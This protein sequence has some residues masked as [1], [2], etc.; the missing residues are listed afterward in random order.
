M[1]HGPMDI[2]KKISAYLKTDLPD[3][4]LRYRNHWQLDDKMLPLPED[5]AYQTYHPAT[6]L[7]RTQDY[8][9]IFTV[10]LNTPR[11]S[12]YGYDRST[13]DPL[14]QCEYN[15]RTYVWV[16]QRGETETAESRDYMITLVRSALLDHQSFRSYDDNDSFTEVKFDEGTMFEEYSDLMALQGE[17]YIAGGFVGYVLTVTEKNSQQQIG[18][19]EEFQLQWEMLREDD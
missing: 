15:A 6:I 2:K 19:V 18:T 4:I 16:K 5:K 9:A 13:D 17:Y 7:N 11:I 12:R 14:Y 8:P 1:M 3:R 10:I